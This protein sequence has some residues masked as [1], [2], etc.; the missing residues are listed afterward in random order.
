MVTTYSEPDTVPGW[1]IVGVDTHAD[2][3]HAAVI[4]MHGRHL[5]D[6][7]FPTTI[8]GYQQLLDWAAG[9]GQIDTVGIELTGSYGAALTRHLTA[10]GVTVRE[11]NTTDKATRARR[12]KDDQIDAYSAAEKVL[13]GMATAIPK[14]TTGNTEAIRVLTLTRNSAVTAR[15]TTWN[16]VKAVLVTA[17]APLREQLRGLSKARLKTTLAHM[18]TPAGTDT[19]TTATITALRR[20]ATRIITLSTEILDADR[21]LNTLVAA[22]AP[23]LLTRPGI[24]THTAARFLICVAD[25]GG[26]IRSEAALARLTGACPV[27]VSSGKT[28]RMRLNRGGD[29]QAN[30]ALHMVIV[31]RLKYDN[32]TRDYR[33]RTL[34]RGHSNRDAIRSLKRALARAI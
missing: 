14:D 2:T 4:D 9:L 26:R 11:V 7:G 28:N 17:P 12:G 8:A 16:Q 13:A 19:V 21:D 29:R 23:T 34:A 30:S 32:T 27:P 18:E 10:A 20:L 15:T 25:N 1:V 5:A 3:H 33:D 22:T 31:S 6:H 24:N